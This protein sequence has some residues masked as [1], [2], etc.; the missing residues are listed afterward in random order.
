MPLGYEVVASLA[1][2]HGKATDAV[3]LSRVDLGALLRLNDR[4][5]RQIAEARLDED[6]LYFVSDGSAIAALL[7]DS[8]GS[9]QVARVDGYNVLLPKW[10]EGMGLSALMS[11]A[12]RR[13]RA[14]S[15]S[16]IGPSGMGRPFCSDCEGSSRKNSHPCRSPFALGP[17]L[18]ST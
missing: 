3:Y 16:R 13:S 8:D 10:K 1:A 17:R 6:T 4:V 12:R 2:N 14:W 11:G 5:G 15:S 18:R 7:A 9:D